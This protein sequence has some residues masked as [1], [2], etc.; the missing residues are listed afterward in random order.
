MEA[1][2]IVLILKMVGTFYCAHRA[3][4]LNRAPGGWAV[5]G[6]FLPIIAMIWISLLKKVT[7]WVKD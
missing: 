3:I 2:I 5:F 7:T 4:A 1:V 6:F